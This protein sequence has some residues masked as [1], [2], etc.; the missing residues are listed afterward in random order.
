MRLGLFYT[1]KR[2]GDE[3]PRLAAVGVGVG[4]T[5]DWKRDIEFHIFSDRFWLKYCV[6]RTCGLLVLEC[7]RKILIL[8]IL[9]AKY[10]GIRS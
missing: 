5:W 6:V 1:S 8:K 4:A 9:H 3:L 10:C 7:P 2:R